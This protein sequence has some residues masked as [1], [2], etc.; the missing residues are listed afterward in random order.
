[1]R[2][3]KAKI[4]LT[5]NDKLII[6][7]ALVQ[8]SKKT[9]SRFQSRMNRELAKKMINKNVID[10]FDGQELTMMAIALEQAAGSSP[11][12]QYKQMYKQMA[13]KLILEKKEFH[14]IAFQELSKRYLYN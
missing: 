12:P 3:T 11:N 4:K 1:M 10:T 9:G 5:L 2:C 7:N 13:R 14:R 8:W 6:V